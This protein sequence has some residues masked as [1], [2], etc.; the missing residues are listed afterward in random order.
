MKRKAVDMKE[1]PIPKRQRE[2]IPEY[3]DVQPRKDDQGVILWPASQSAIEDAQA[4]LKEWYV[5]E[6]FIEIRRRS[7]P[8]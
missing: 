3:C 6:P 7:L 4:F 8:G 1:S 2:Q 5:L